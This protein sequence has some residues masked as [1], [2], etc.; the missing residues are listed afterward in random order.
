MRPIVNEY[1]DRFAARGHADLVREL[2]FPFPVRVV[3][4]M[5][6]LPEEDHRA[7]PPRLPS[8]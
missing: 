4:A 7:L 2:T 3:A 6:G 5:M 1:V 8:N